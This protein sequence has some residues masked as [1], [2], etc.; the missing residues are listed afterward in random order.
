MMN[1]RSTDA[2][3]GRRRAAGSPVP[4]VLGSLWEDQVGSPVPVVLGSLERTRWGRQ[5]RWC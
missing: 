1:E 4:A 5:Y 2:G 3:I